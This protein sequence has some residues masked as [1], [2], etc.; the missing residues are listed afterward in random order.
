MERQHIAIFAL[1]TAGHMNPL[2]GLSAKLVERGHRVTFPADAGYASRV[3]QTGATP[4]LWE[5]VSAEGTL[6]RVAALEHQSIPD[7]EWWRLRASILYPWFLLNSA[8]EVSQLGATYAADAPDLILYDRLAFAGRIIGNRLNAPLIQTYPHFAYYNGLLHRQDG[9]CSNPPPMLDFAKLLDDFLQA[10]GISDTGNLWHT[11]KHNLF[12]IPRAFQF[13]QE[14]FDDRYSFVGACL[15]RP[16]SR[17]WKSRDPERPL[18]LVSDMAGARSPY[19]DL[20]I[21]SLSDLDAHVVLSIGADLNA[22]D[23]KAL[24]SNFE[25]NQHSSHLEILPHAALAICQGGMGSTLEALYH[26]VPVIALPL[27]RFHEEVAYRTAELGLGFSLPRQVVTADKIRE[28]VAQALS[29]AVLKNRVKEMQ[30]RFRAQDGAE[31][32]ANTIESFIANRRAK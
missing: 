16:F 28:C 31:L 17:S 14:S 26:G 9:V 8:V 3:A 27:T 24:P 6:G 29:D 11:E 5:P 7:L 4:F 10:Y 21:D 32:A 2:L 13:Y 18:I 1:L 19:F 12:F 20:F 15:N 22:A 30:P 25:I 23:L